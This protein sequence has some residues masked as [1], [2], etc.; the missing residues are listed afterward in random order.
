[1]LPLYGAPLVGEEANI[2]TPGFLPGSRVRDCEHWQDSPSEEG[3]F[4]STRASF[5]SERRRRKVLDSRHIF[6]NSGFLYATRACYQ[7]AALTKFPCP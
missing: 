1:M 4:C 2:P 6:L 5:L 3:M 7:L